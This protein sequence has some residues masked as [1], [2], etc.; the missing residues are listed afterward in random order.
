MWTNLAT[1]YT[2]VCGLEPCVMHSEEFSLYSFLIRLEN[3]SPPPSQQVY[4]ITS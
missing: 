1:F 3:H 4:L 2:V